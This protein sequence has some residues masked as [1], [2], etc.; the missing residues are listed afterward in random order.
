M[1][2]NEVTITK[3]IIDRYYEK[4]INNLENGCCR[5]R[6]GALGV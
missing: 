2:L 6:R 5:C 3:A 1:E 4:L